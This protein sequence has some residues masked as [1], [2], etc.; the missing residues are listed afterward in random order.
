MGP[1]R[2]WLDPRRLLM[3]VNDLRI[4]HYSA[5]YFKRTKRALERVDKHTV[6]T[7]QVFQKKEGVML[8]G[9]QEAIAILRAGAGTFR[10]WKRAEE[11]YREDL[12]V[13][14][15]IQNALLRYG[16]ERLAALYQ[17]HAE[18]QIELDELWEPGFE[19][20]EVWALQDGDLI[21]PWESV[22]H[23]TGDYSLF[24]HLESLYLGVLADR[25]TVATN[26]YRVVQAAGG[27]PV[28]FF[29]DRFKDYRS[30]WGDGYA[31][32]VAGVAGVA[33]DAQ[34]FWWYGEGLGTMPHAL[35]AVHYGDTV[36]AARCFHEAFPEVNLIVLVDFHND[37]VTTSLEAA[38]AF[39]ERL[40]GVRLDTAETLVDRSIREEQ[41]GEI[42]PTGV[43]PQLV[44]NV[45]QALDREGFQHVKIVVSGGF[46]AE[47]IAW[48]E[49]HG[50]PADAYGVGSA[51]VKGGIDFTADIVLV[52]GR[53]MAKV[54]RRYHPNPRMR[55]VDWQEPPRPLETGE[56]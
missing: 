17:R 26:T 12:I 28:L 39:G 55:K 34:A 36:A 21:E 45:R 3:P 10:D 24:A 16:E 19:V 35:I 18:I 20:L 42:P 46:N 52:E 2:P 4:G 53:P 54:G 25:T 8:C 50:V 43:S 30:Q 1:R 11:L 48:F 44:E 22:M 32:W 9:V 5:K 56:E 7:M 51:L 47:R 29:A 23:I 49:K 41:M 13:R 6:G 38:R 31:A 14:Q 27:K 33:T 40:W 37:C 15:R